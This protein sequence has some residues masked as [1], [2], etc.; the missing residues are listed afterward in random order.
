MSKVGRT[1]TITLALI[2]NYSSAPTIGTLSIS[3]PYTAVGSNNAPNQVLPGRDYSSGNSLQGTISGGTN[4]M[5]PF[6]YNNG[7]ITS[8]SGA[9]VVFSGTYQAN[10]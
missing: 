6:A 5:V 4:S 1:V 10:Q 3:L 2:I 8:A 9:V 7:W